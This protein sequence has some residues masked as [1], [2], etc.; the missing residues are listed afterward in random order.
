MLSRQGSGRSNDRGLLILSRQGPIVIEIVGPDR[1]N[2]FY[3]QCAGNGRIP[4]GAFRY[5]VALYT[6]GYGTANKAHAP[7]LDRAPQMAAKSRS[8]DRE[9][10]IK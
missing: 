5:A 1:Q 9:T 7:S 10:C 2:Y 6:G 3:N 4:A 8:N